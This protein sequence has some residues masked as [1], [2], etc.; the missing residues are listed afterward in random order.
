MFFSVGTSKGSEGESAQRRARSCRIRTH[1]WTVCRVTDTVNG[2][3]CVCGCANAQITI[4]LG[5]PRAREA[6]S[7]RHSM[8]PPRRGV[9]H[10]RV[11]CVYTS[12]GTRTS[13]RRSNDYGGVET[14]PRQDSFSPGRVPRPAV[15]PA[16]TIRGCLSPWTGFGEGICPPVRFVCGV[17]GETGLEGTFGPSQGSLCSATPD[18]VFPLAKRLVRCFSLSKSLVPTFSHHE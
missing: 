15:G 14:I 18:H 7:V 17:V 2:R 6:H 5:R 3:A 11:Q 1:H 12:L 13:T 8:G 9:P 4:P 16:H 10:A